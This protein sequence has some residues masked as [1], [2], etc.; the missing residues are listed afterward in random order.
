[1]YCFRWAQPTSPNPLPKRQTPKERNEWRD[2]SRQCCMRGK[3]HFLFFFS[4]DGKETK[5]QAPSKLRPHEMLTHPRRWG[6]PPRRSHVWKEREVVMRFSVPSCFIFALRFLPTCDA[7]GIAQSTRS[8]AIPLLHV[9]LQRSG[10][11]I[12]GGCNGRGYATLGMAWTRTYHPCRKF[13]SESEAR[14][15]T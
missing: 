15:T 1:M 11:A 2:M 10:K 3:M 8:F 14:L 6:R 12:G 7:Y 9:S 5:D 13:A 4:L